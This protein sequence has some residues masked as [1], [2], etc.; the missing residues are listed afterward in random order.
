MNLFMTWFAENLGTILVGGLLIATVML[1]VGA[2]ATWRTAK[3]LR[4]PPRPLLRFCLSLVLLLAGAGALAVLGSGLVELGPGM[5]AQRGMLGEPAPVLEFALVESDRPGS[6]ADFRGQVVLV[7][8]WATWC[9]PCRAEMADL[10]RLQRAHA[11][12]GLV[13]LHL[14]D[15]DRDT[16]LAWIED[17]PASTLHAYA[18]PIP[19]PETGRPTTYVVDREGTL[20]R[21]LLGQRSYEQFETEI[22]RFL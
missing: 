19:W 16:L 5:W 22:Q 7:N 14:S 15:E 18:Q 13:I 9:P 17:Q 2:L 8:M 4:H 1:L 10:D 6:L 12:E 11:E 20:Q 21:V 3:R